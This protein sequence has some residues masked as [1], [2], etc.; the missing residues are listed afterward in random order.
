MIISD[1][2]DGYNESKAEFSQVCCGVILVLVLVVKKVFA[3]SLF[4]SFLQPSDGVLAVVF[5]EIYGC[6][7]G[8]SI[9]HR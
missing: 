2:K 3:V 6:H 9:G 8:F 7:G 1:K 5:Q 4:I